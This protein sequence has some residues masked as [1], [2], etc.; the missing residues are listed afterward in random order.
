MDKNAL[1]IAVEAYRQRSLT[2]WLLISGAA[3]S[4]ILCF[5][6][7]KTIVLVK[8]YKQS[9]EISA[10]LN[11][12][13][14]ALKELWGSHQRLNRIRKNLEKESAFFARTD[15]GSDLTC[16]AAGLGPESYLTEITFCNGHCTLKGCAPNK[17]ELHA[18]VDRLKQGLN[19]EIVYNSE[20]S[21]GHLFEIKCVSPEID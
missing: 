9:L 21:P 8:A 6:V 10:T 1:I 12:D 7:Y 13:I 18:Y 2:L 5:L 11:N 14:Q 19:P 3:L 20:Q 15:F 4:I 16:I 17:E